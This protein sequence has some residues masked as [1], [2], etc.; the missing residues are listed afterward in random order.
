MR[1]LST[2]K[3]DGPK[4]CARCQRERFLGLN[5]RYRED[6]ESRRLLEALKRRSK[7][8]WGYLHAC[9]ICSAW[10]YL[11]EDE[12]WIQPVPEQRRDLLREWNDMVLTL[13]DEAFVG[14]RVIGATERDHY[15]NHRGRYRVPC[16]VE[17][18]DGS[19]TDPA[20]V[21]MT[22]IPPI[23]ADEPNVQL[24]KDIRSVRP[25]EF[26]LAPEVRV[27]TLHAPEVRM[28]FAPTMVKADG[29]RYVLNWATDLVTIAKPR[30]NHLALG[31]DDIDMSAVPSIL[32]EDRSQVL[33]LYADWFPDVDSMLL[34]GADMDDA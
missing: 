2:R 16:S 10:W 13:S 31:A 3:T 23:S 24:F 11:D 20:L 25:T 18:A 7:L 33:F 9:T 14:L 4:G 19:R 29:V 30:G 27:A 26:A 15:G 6:S 1:I 17:R 22:K 21:I 32:T 12:I 5:W 34:P 8:K 28:G